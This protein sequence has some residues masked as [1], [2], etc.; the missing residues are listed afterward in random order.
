M[1]VA[2]LRFL[3]VI[4]DSKVGVSAGIIELMKYEKSLLAFLFLL[5]VP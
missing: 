4:Y 1:Y 5:N 2:I 3:I